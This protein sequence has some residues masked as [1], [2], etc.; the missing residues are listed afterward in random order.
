MSKTIIDA[1]AILR[2]ILQDNLEQADAAEEK[3]KSPETSIPL[4]ILAEVVFV[5]QKVYKVK[6]S[7]IAKNLKNLIDTRK[8][9]VVENE[10]ALFAMNIYSSTSLGF[11]DCLLAGYFKIKNY[12]IFTFDKKLQRKIKTL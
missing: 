7:L 6:R 8:D 3:L 12:S 1:N 2:F 10:V 9:L 4:E 5:L 11:A